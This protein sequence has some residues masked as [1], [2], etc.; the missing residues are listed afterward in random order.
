MSIIELERLDDPRVSGYHAVSDPD[1]LRR[2]NQFVA[3]GRL[4][5][6]RLVALGGYQ[7]RSLLLSTAACAALQREGAALPDVP[8]Y[9]CSTA[10]FRQL[11]GLNLHRGCLA[12]VDRPEP[13]RVGDLMADARLVVALEAV[14][15][16]DNIGGI[17]RNAAAFGVD[18]V[19][20]GPGCADPLYRKAIRTSMA[21]VLQVPYAVVER[22][23]AD[24]E[25]MR[26][27]QFHIAAL[28]PG[29]SAQSIDSFVAGR[30][31]SRVVLVF[32]AEGTGLAAG[33]LAAADSQVRIPISSRVDS[34]NVVV[35]CGI[36]LAVLRSGRPEFGDL[37]TA[38]VYSPDEPSHQRD[39]N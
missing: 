39:T 24:L 35:A 29:T 1:L 17:F 23:P 3:E 31:F 18:A 28:T 15:N 32:G 19:L 7:I 13:R 27:S 22:W 21:A 14:A 37:T 5:V 33:T 25:L 36:A 30:R 16:P 20:L 9:V 12:L 38:P 10:A 26:H 8:I 11:A 34:L 4:V 2:R 6:E